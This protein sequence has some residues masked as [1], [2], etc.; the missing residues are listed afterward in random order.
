MICLLL[1]SCMASNNGC[2]QAI[3]ADKPQAWYGRVNGWADMQKTKKEIRL[4]NK[5]GVSGYMIELAGCEWSPPKNMRHWSDEWINETEKL[6]AE[7]LEYCRHRN[8]WLFVSIVNDNMGK[9]K[10]GDTGP[11]LRTVMFQAQKL[12]RIV[13]KYGNANVIVQ[14]V[15]ETQTQAGREFEAYCIKELPEFPLVYNGDSGF[16]DSVLPGMDYRAVHPSSIDSSLPSDAFIISDHGLIIRELAD[17][18]IDAAGN[19][20]TIRQWVENAR[21]WKCPVIGYYCFK[22]NNVDKNAIKALGESV[23]NNP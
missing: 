14:P 11:D 21:K 15:A 22:Y 12:C 8:I 6:Y 5:Y 3:S 16:S 20:Q 19:P 2:P 7:L 10:Y 13:K 17:G 4:C 1:C 9:G 18:K 23:R